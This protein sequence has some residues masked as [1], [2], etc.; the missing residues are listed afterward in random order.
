MGLWANSLGETL[1]ES[2]LSSLEDKEVAR[3]LII[4][5]SQKMAT[6]EPN[7]ETGGTFSVP[8][9]LDSPVSAEKMEAPKPGSTDGD[10]NCIFLCEF[11]PIAG[12]KI[13]IQVPK[14]H[15]TNDLFRIVN[16]YIIPK[17]PLQRSFLS[18]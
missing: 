2:P 13:I 1:S 3:S 7:D 17:V 12:P 6:T 15:V 10:V 5:E 8:S 4:G 9:D 18:V 16:Q 11:H 14:D